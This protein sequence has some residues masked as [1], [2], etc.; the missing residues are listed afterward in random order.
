VRAAVVGAGL[1]GLTA[2]YEL[3]L[4]G[5]DVTVFE[6]RGRVGGRVW[7]RR[8]DNGAVIEMGAEF[9][10]PGNTAIRELAERFGL[11]LWEKGMRYGRREP[12]GGLG[13]T[14]EEL[15]AVA[16]EVERALPSAPPGMSA[17]AFL[18]SLDL[19]DGPR[20][21]LIARVE[22]SSAAPAGDVAA[23][24]LAGIAHVDG[25]PAPSIAGGNQRVAL[26]LAAELGE[27]VWL[28]APVERVAWRPTA[29]GGAAAG[30]DSG[31]PSAVRI[32]AAGS[33]LETDACVIA[34]PVTV[35]DRIAFD[36]PLPQEVAAPLRRVRYGHAAK[37]FVPLRT[38][39]AP[40]AVMSVPE[41]YWTWTATGDGGRVQAVVSA[42]AGS[43]EALDR[44]GVGQGPTRWLDSLT[45]LRPELELDPAGAVLST[46]T[47]DP[48]SRAAYS[49]SPPPELAQS[50]AGQVGPLAF[51]GEHLGGEFAAL[52]EGAVRS[53][54]RAARALT[55]GPSGVP[56]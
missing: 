10:L 27:R 22:I 45:A 50:A 6:A 32:R 5:A 23:R 44:L 31:A 12:R 46:W 16:A 7:S 34:V 37:L 40:T 54:R 42:F 41:R 13:T 26:A 30:A 36:P 2:A 51:A 33:E 9:L 38:A 25:E 28:R 49:T 48:W 1:G 53:G 4:A 17:R 56:A 11:G 55:G 3:Q 19:P 20:D 18:E 21:A 29:S 8:L 43:A 24:D 39:P 47:D 14:T 15:E 35:L 52:M